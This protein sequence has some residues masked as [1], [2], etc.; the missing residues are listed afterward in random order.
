MY[1]KKKEWKEFECKG[2]VSFWGER[3]NEKKCERMRK[4]ENGKIKNEKESESNDNIEK[5]GETAIAI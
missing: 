5:H 3:K 2:S 4:N 1:G